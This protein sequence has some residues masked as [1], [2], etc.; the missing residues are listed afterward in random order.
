MYKNAQK[1]WL[2]AFVTA[3]IGAGI[4]TSLAVAQGQNPF[5]ALAITAFAAGMAVVIDHFC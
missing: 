1:D 3:A 2:V 5:L 4:I